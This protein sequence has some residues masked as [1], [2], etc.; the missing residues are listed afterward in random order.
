MEPQG[1]PGAP[2][3]PSGGPSGGPQEASRGHRETTRVHKTRGD[4]RR[5]D[6]RTRHWRW[7]LERGRCHP[8]RFHML[9]KSLF[10]TTKAAATSPVA[11][12]RFVHL[13]HGSTLVYLHMCG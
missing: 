8:T 7:C 1:P 6:N 13:M 3:W 12:L 2:K 9:T 4:K 11:N 10:G 5:Q